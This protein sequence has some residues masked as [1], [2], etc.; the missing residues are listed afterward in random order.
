MP[1]IDHPRTIRSFVL[2]AG[3]MGSGQQRALEELGPR[4]VLPYAAAPLDLEATFGRSAP[5][6]LEIGFGMGDSTASI[7]ANQPENDFLG[8]EVH[9]PGVGA[10]LKR[11]G[12]A[13]LTNLRIVQHDAVEV[14]RADARAGL[15]GRRAYLFPRPL[16][17]EAP[18]QAAPDPAGVGRSVGEPFE[19]GRLSASSHRLAGLR[20]TDA[21][22]SCKAKLLANTADYA[23]RPAYRPLTKFEQR[24]LRLG[25]GVWDLIFRRPPRSAR[26]LD[27]AAAGERRSMIGARMPVPHLPLHPVVEAQL[28]VGARTDA[29]V[30]AE[31]PVVQVVRACRPA[32]R[33]RKSRS[34]RRPACASIAS[35]RS[36]MSAARS[37]SG[38]AAGSGEQRV[39]LEREVVAATSGAADRPAP[40]QVA[41]ER[42]HRLPRQRVHQVDVEGGEVTR[43]LLD[44]RMRLRRVMHAADRRSNPS[45]KL[46][47]PI[48]KRVTP[49][50]ANPAKR[51]VSK[52]ARVG[53]ERDL[54][55]G[56]SGSGPGSWPAAPVERGR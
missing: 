44:R 17:Q 41:I 31:L 54:G 12:A 40:V 48:D 34:V 27:E 42:R 23:P 49:A 4:F 46:C 19:A 3:R 37:S 24:G 30:V 29:Q 10:L 9:T 43:G 45:S 28:A 38:T 22:T 51:P 26:F 6:I 8:I 21:T 18:P 35:T 25:H 13:G 20:R 52:R 39:R 47:T 33:R 55:V 32:A 15:P 14:L 7:A 36:C 53:L 2:R 1:D 11:I 50:R 56:L 5:K 16:A